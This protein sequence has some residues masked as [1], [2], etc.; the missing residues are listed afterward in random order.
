MSATPL[1]I[2]A[3][4][5]PRRGFL[6]RLS[7]LDG[8]RGRVRGQVLLL[9]CA[10]YFITYIDRVNIATT[11]PFIQKDLGLDN[12][13]LGLVFSAFAIPYAFFQIFGGYIGDRWGPK[14]VLALVGLIWAVSTMATGFATGLVSLFA[15]RLLLGFGEGAAF[16]TATN[17]MAKWVPAEGRARAQ[18]YVHAAS[19]IGNAITPALV[20]VLIALYDWRLSFWVCGSVSLIWTLVWIVKYHNSPAKHPGITQEELSELTPDQLSD[21]RVPIPWGPLLKRILPVTFVDFCYGWSLWVFLSWIPSFFADRFGMN[22]KHFAFFTTIVLIAGVIGDAMGGILS[23]TLVK[24][25]SQTIAR[26]TNL[27]VGL[28]GAFV[29]VMPVLF[30]SNV[31]MVAISLALSFFFLE[32]T[33]SVLWAIP[34]DVDPQHAGLGGGIMNTGFGIAGIISPLLFGV[35]LD[36]YGTWTMPFAVSAALPFVGAA[37]S[38]FIN[39]R[40]LAQPAE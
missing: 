33:N 2:S 16:P 32:L 6:S 7:I 29:F 26:R 25:T 12:T 35:M 31:W 8:F 4:R 9:L 20:A 23:D 21:H 18:G 30:L 24:R 11:A 15:A 39:P 19:R 38:L 40:P 34:M 14:R 28:V 27:V 22:L 3:G 1:S 10:M 36:A 5:A 17:A 37:V 13:E